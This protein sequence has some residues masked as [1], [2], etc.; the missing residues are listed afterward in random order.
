VLRHVPL[1]SH[2][3]ARGAARAAICAEDLGAKDGYVDALFTTQDL[4]EAGCE[5][6]AAQ[7]GVDRDAF[8]RC[9]HSPLVDERMDRDIAA[10]RSADG[11]GVPL[12]FVGAHRIDGAQPRS[13]FEA[14]LD[15]AIAGAQ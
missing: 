13:V 3:D 9:V 14:A 15:D 10:Y 4:S 8:R 11:D 7:R 2:P 6:L 5:D 12:V 1:P